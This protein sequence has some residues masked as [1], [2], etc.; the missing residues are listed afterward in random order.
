MLTPL[1]GAD[2]RLE[3]AIA[4]Q[5]GVTALKV[6]KAGKPDVTLIFEQV[7]GALVGLAYEKTIKDGRA[8]QATFSYSDFQNFS[9]FVAPRTI[10]YIDSSGIETT[11]TVESIEPLES[12]PRPPMQLD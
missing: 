12:F 5:E 3:K 8:F 2:Y 1:L 6:H 9:G 7:K 11:T 10:K 4:P